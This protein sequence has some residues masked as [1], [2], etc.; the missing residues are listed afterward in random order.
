MTTYNTYSLK[1]RWDGTLVSQR[2]TTAKM[3]D[4]Q[5]AAVLATMTR[6]YYEVSPIIN[7]PRRML[8]TWTCLNTDIHLVVHKDTESTHRVIIKRIIWRD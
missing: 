2:V 8:L 1:E 4:K 3:T 5:V 6:L 7:T